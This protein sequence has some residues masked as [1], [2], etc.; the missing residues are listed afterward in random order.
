M[1]SHPTANFTEARSYVEALLRNLGIEDFTV[2][3]TSHPSFIDGRT[4]EIR[5][6]EKR[7]GIVGEIHP[8]VLNNFDL[9]NP[10]GAF[11]IN[12]EH[13]MERLSRKTLYSNR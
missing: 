4:A 8:A 1:T 13:L 10:T 2:K 3:S 7:I 12:L 5:I 11:E 6:E 9:E